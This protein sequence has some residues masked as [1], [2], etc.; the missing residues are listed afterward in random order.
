MSEDLNRRIGDLLDAYGRT[1]A[2]E[3]G[4]SL[5][6][7]PAPLYQLAVLSLLSSIPI[8]ANMA[9]AAAREL[10][11]AGLRTPARMAGATW[12]H[13]VDLL[14]RAH[15]RR[16]DEST[17]TALG[18]G[19]QIVIDRWQGD[20]RRL[21]GEALHDPCRIRTLLQELPRIGPVG[22]DIFCR[23]A[24]GVWPELQPSFDR[25]AAQGARG[26][27]LPTEPHKLAALVPQEDVTRLAAAL[28][29]ST[30]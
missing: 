8:R 19:A 25:R 6:D 11:A 17:S 22:A 20:L 26:A 27:G 15:Y 12:Q 3:A 5:R 2:D 21:R 30:L 23:E 10:F 18:E 13:R 1:F 4:I 14:G 16:Y 24:Q 28:V 9:V 7:T 29:R